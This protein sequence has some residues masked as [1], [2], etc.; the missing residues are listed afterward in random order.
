M[1]AVDPRGAADLLA[2]AKSQSRRARRA[3]LD[4]MTDLF[5]SPE[6]RLSDQDRA[7]MADIIGKLVDDVEIE[8][9]RALAE[10]LALLPDAPKA[11][12]LKLANDEVR[13]ARPLLMNSTVLKDA[14]LIEVVRQRSQEHR[15]SVAMRSGIGP[16]VGD[17]LLEFGEEDVIEALIRNPDAVLSRQALEYLV[18]ESRRLDQ[19]Q[20]PLLRRE[21]LP[22]ALAYR[23][24]WWVSAAL[25]RMILAEYKLD[26]SDLDRFLESAVHAVV[27]A[28]PKGDSESIKLAARLIERGEMTERRLIQT[29]RVGH[30]N[31]FIAGLAHMAGINAPTARRIV[32]APGGEAM[33]VCCKAAGFDRGTYSTIYLLLRGILQPGVPMTPKVLEEIM[34]IYARMTRENA[35]LALSY[36]M[37]DADYLDAV[38]KVERAAAESES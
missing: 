38:A 12:I 3:L 18:E 4:N 2:L 16:A 26:E 31:A 24:F 19:F 30:V 22:S 28:M 35:R 11:L 6:G 15:L 7:Q 10:R 9:R 25:R 5:L 20:E 36:W 21:D 13:V 17:A 29:L 33:A 14:D 27:G 34:E 8:V 32:F 23:M 37:R 1:T